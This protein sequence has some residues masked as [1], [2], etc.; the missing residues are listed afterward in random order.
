MIEAFAAG[1]NFEL[2][3]H[4][5]SMKTA[6]PRINPITANKIKQYGAGVTVLTTD[7]CP[8]LP[9]A[10]DIFDGAAAELGLGCQIIK[11]KSAQQAQNN[12]VN[13]NGTF[14]VLYNGQVVTSKYE[15]AEKFK[16]MITNLE[17][18]PEKLA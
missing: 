5:F 16:T 4:K 8:Y 14:A 9:D 6:D 10:V 1:S 17:S 12:G 15:K 3:V 7:Q 13:P 18:S 2:Y 11:L